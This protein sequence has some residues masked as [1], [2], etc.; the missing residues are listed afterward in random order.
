MNLCE[1]QDGQCVCI[2]T[3]FDFD[4]TGNNCVGKCQTI[5]FKP[6][7]PCKEPQNSQFHEPTN[8]ANEMQQH[9]EEW[10]STKKKHNCYEPVKKVVDKCLWSLYLGN[11]K[12]EAWG[13]DLVVPG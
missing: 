11:N 12:W 9:F 5:L 1:N 10:V 8:N 6:R 3:G 2:D 13:L 7:K 4:S